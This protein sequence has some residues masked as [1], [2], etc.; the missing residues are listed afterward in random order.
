MKSLWLAL[1]LAIICSAVH[2]D[3][4]VIINK[5]S[6][7]L[8]VQSK[9]LNLKT[10]DG[11]R[12]FFEMKAGET[13]TV[14]FGADFRVFMLH[15]YPKDHMANAYFYNPPVSVLQGPCKRYTLT[16]KPDFSVQKEETP[17]N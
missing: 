11:K 14:E 4:Y 15:I 9:A 6:D 1:A 5:S 16:M 8:K 13:K 3:S 12:E 17:C 10:Q 2:A 7:D